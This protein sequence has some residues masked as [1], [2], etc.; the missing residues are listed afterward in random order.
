MT[1]QRDRGRT[2]DTSRGGPPPLHGGKPAT[3]SRD[4]SSDGASTETRHGEIGPVDIAVRNRT[5]HGAD[6]ADTARRER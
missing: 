1:R 4:I 3:Y 2:G 5:Y 6:Q